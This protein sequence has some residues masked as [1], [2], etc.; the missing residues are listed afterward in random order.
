VPP[1]GEARPDWW[2]AAQFARH[3]AARLAPDKQRLFDWADAAAVFADYAPLTAGRDLDI[4]ALDHAQLAACGPLQWPVRTGAAQGTP[5]LYT[6]GR[7]ATDD[8]RARFVPLALRGVAEE[9]SAAYPL[10]LTTVRLRDQWHG[11][12]RSGIAPALDFPPPAIHLAP[13]TA[14]QAH[15]AHDDLVV[16]STARGSALLPLAIDDSLAAGQASVPMHYGRRWLFGTGNRSGINGL[17]L[18]AVDPLSRQPEL[19][20]AAARLQP[21]TFD[22][23]L[24]AC[25]LLAP[26][27]ALE[28]ADQWRQRAAALPFASLA[29]FGRV[30]G[31]TGLVLQAAGTARDAALIE[32]LQQWLA[33]DDDAPRLQDTRA[34]RARR[35]KL[36][37]GRLTAVLLEGRSRRDIA[38]VATYRR[39][40][41]QG[42]DCS[43]RSLRELL[44]PV[45]ATP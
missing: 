16:V 9:V 39:L 27:A 32:W 11:A 28:A 20:H 38:A 33:F 15:L 26:A 41:G 25:A 10:A 5:R 19:K 22:W 23:H 24:A 42:T 13:W 4:A 6:D 35:L 21:A 12:S 37:Q 8:G 29:F 3:L 17:T 2:I 45:Q 30:A 18:P 43:G 7:F 40:I 44:L 1:P 34:G 14:A 31:A 36:A